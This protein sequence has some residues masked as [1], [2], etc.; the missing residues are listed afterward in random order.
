MFALPL[1]S[2]AEEEPITEASQGGEAFI[3]FLNWLFPA[4]LSLAAILAFAMIVFGGFKWIAAAGNPPDISDAKDMIIKAVLG[5]ILAFASWLILNTINPA[6][7][8]GNLL[9]GGGPPPET[10]TYYRCEN[11]ES[12]NVGAI[13]KST[14]PADALTQ[15]KNGCGVRYDLGAVTPPIICNKVEENAPPFLFDKYVCDNQPNA[16]PRT[17]EAICLANCTITG[18]ETGTCSNVGPNPQKSHKCS[19]ANNVELNGTGYYS[20]KQCETACSYI[21]SGLQTIKGACN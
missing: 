13:Y 7:V 19:I 14:D 5:L 4:L 18:L 3:T 11:P 15:C 2:F 16:E 12:A 6:L 20:K 21:T 8:T 1:L 9:G 17:T 10:L